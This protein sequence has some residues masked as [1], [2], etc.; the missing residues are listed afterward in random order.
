MIPN[1][2]NTDALQL[3][4]LPDW[5][6]GVQLEI[7]AQTKIQTATSGLEQRF[8]LRARPIFRMTYTETGLAAGDL[9]ARQRRASVE[10]LRPLLAP[11]WTERALVVTGTT[12]QV[13]IDRDP[14]PDF[15]AAGQSIA[16]IK[17]DGTIEFRTITAVAVRTL[18]TSTGSFA[19][20]P[21]VK[22]YPARL[23]R[24]LPGNDGHT[25]T[26]QSQGSETISVETL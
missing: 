11:F 4:R 10:L 3:V 7:V 6:L 2:R 21:G 24:R 15:Y 16:I 23:C 25:L 22:A 9:R 20:A 1:S 13:V 8:R 12:T 17:P 26:T 19:P 18:S 5:S 14:T